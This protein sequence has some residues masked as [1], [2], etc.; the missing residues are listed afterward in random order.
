MGWSSNLDSSSAIAYALAVARVVVFL[1][2]MVALAASSASGAGQPRRVLFIGDSLT[3]GTGA[4]DYP[5]DFAWMTAEA[6]GRRETVDRL[7]VA[8]G[9]VTTAYWAARP[10]AI[11]GNVNLAVVELGTNDAHSV[12]APAQFDTTYRKLLDEIRAKSPRVKFVCLSVWRPDNP[13]AAA[14]Y[15][16][17]IRADCPG[18]YVNIDRFAHAPNLSSVDGFHPDN[19]GHSLIAQAILNAL[20]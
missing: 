4:S 20:K 10:G 3:V 16:A 13:P 2:V 19:A 8:K 5:H 11:P 18:R 7:I 6:L 14:S 12:P 9:G 1:A 15:D 17:T